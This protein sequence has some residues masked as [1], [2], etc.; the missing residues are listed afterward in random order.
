VRPHPGRSLREVDAAFVDYLAARA[1]D[2]RLPPWNEWFEKD[3]LAQVL[4]DPAAR[5]AF[6]ADLPRTPLAFLEAAAPVSDTWEA[7]PAA[8]LQLSRR[9][10]MQADWAESRGWPVARRGLH[11]LAMATH[12]Y[13]IAGLIAGLGRQMG[14]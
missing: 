14:L 4:P 1:A 9:Y 7:L 8:Y 6:V 5:D 3:L 10:A 13:E 12:P 11:H 2:G